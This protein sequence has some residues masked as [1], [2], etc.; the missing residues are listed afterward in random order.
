MIIK[1]ESTDE[2]DELE[3]DEDIVVYMDSDEEDTKVQNQKVEEE[4]TDEEEEEYTF[5]P[6]KEWIPAEKVPY[7]FMIFQPVEIPP[8]GD[9]SPV[10][11][12]STI[13]GSYGRSVIIGSRPRIQPSQN[14]HSNRTMMMVTADQLRIYLSFQAEKHNKKAKAGRKNRH[15]RVTDQGLCYQLQVAVIPWIGN[16]LIPAKNRVTVADTEREQGEKRQLNSTSIFLLF[17]HTMSVDTVGCKEIIKQSRNKV[18]QLAPASDPSSVKLKNLTS[19]KLQEHT[20]ILDQLHVLQQH[21]QMQLQQTKQVI[22]LQQTPSPD[23]PGVLL[24]IHPTTPPQM[25]FPPTVFISQPVQQLIQFTPPST[26]NKPGGEMGS[27]LSAPQK[28]NS[29]PFAVVTKPGLNQLSASPSLSSTKTSANRTRTKKVKIQEKVLSSPHSM[30]GDGSG[31]VSTGVDTEEDS[32]TK[33]R[34]RIRKPTEKAKALQVTIKEKAESKKKNTPQRQQMKTALPQTPPSSLT[35]PITDLKTE[36]PNIP[37]VPMDPAASDRSISSTQNIITTPPP[38]NKD[39]ASFTDSLP[40]DHNYINYPSSSCP[41]VSSDKPSHSTEQKRRPSRSRSTTKKTPKAPPKKRKRASKGGKRSSPKDQSSTKTGD[42]TEKKSDAVTVE[43]EAA[44]AAEDGGS[45]GLPQDGKRVRKPSL[46]AREISQ[47]MAE[48]TKKKSPS[49]SPPKKRARTPRGKKETVT[50]KQLVPVLCLQPSP[51]KWVMTP[52]GMVQLVEMCPQVP[53]LVAAPRTPPQNSGRILK[54]KLMSPPLHTL[55]AHPGPTLALTAS[56]ARP[57]FP[58]PVS[59]TLPAPSSST[60]QLDLSLMSF[61]SPAEVQDWLSGQGG[62]DAPGAGVT[63]PYLPPFVSNLSAL[64]ELLRNKKSL[65]KLS[66]QLL[67]QVSETQ[68]EA[69]TTSK[70]GKI[71]TEKSVQPSQ[72]PDSTSDQTANKLAAPPVDTKPEDEEEVKEEELVAVVRQLVAE[73][74]TSNPAYQLL[75]ARFLSCFTVP[76]LLATFK[77]ISEKNVATE[78]E[79][80]EEE[81]KNEEEQKIKEIL[82]KGKRRR[83]QQSSFQCDMPGPPANHFSGMERHASNQARQDPAAAVDNSLFK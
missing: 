6:L 63:L 13:L 65:T 79:E 73:R 46:K 5:P 14:R 52:S 49:F 75:K 64:S 69:K 54:P 30:E 80:E 4:G 45:T 16:V 32:K 74:F 60:L 10:K 19:K 83:A 12:R 26:P 77:P 11:A 81:D 76:A 72:E 62:V 28:M 61:E 37:S 71:S 57:D 43:G 53:P 7:T 18:V 40:S 38:S 8:T 82:A 50:Q 29:P 31:G 78:E 2:E 35:N 51:P 22:F 25:A 56:P 17:L 23:K 59:S 27:P 41:S 24:K 39:T 67:D 58:N 66:L 36:N 48:A 15:S 3:E 21:K 68:P 1:E 34:G 20:Q 55:A 44:A 9:A 70:A 42:A 33:N 47:A